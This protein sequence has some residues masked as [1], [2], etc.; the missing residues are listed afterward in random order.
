[1]KSNHIVASTVAALLFGLSGSAW[2]TEPEAEPGEARLANRGAV[3]VCEA[4]ERD[5]RV[6]DQFCQLGEMPVYIPPSRGFV[7]TRIGG[8]TRGGGFRS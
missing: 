5:A 1:M 8:A 7:A 3:A 4:A 6:C 2:A